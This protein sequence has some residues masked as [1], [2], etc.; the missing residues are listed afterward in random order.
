LG[1][2]TETG[3]AQILYGS[4]TGLTT[5]APPTIK[6]DNNIGHRINGTSGNDIIDGRG[7]SDTLVA[8]S[9]NDTLLG[10]NGADRLWGNAG[11]DILWGGWGGDRLTGDSGRDTFV[12]GFASGVE[13]ITDFQDGIDL[14]GN[15]SGASFQQLTITQV[16]QNTQI[17]MNGFTL[18]I[19]QNVQA[20]TITANDFVAMGMTTISGIE[21]PVVV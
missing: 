3:A 11:D 14:I 1:Q 15:I 16:N 6:V 10:G 13:T 7:G 2:S 9:G 17:G 4:T 12:L 20:N 21:V 18:A 19:L 5:A 8:S